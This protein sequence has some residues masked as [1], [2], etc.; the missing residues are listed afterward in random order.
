MQ[1]LTL[2]VAY[3]SVRRQKEMG[4]INLLNEIRIGQLSPQGR[5][6]LQSCVKRQFPND[7]IAPTILRTH[8]IS[9]SFVYVVLLT[10]DIRCQTLEKTTWS[11]KMRA[12]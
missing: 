5:A 7:G 9:K 12:F 11:G 10:R 3:L 6:M 1:P 8:H 2:F 4:F